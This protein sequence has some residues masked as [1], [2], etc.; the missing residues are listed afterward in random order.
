MRSPVLLLNK[1]DGN[2]RCF[3]RQKIVAKFKEVV[4]T[5]L[6]VEIESRDDSKIP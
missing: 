5:C 4:F 6:V 3:F 2:S 1:R